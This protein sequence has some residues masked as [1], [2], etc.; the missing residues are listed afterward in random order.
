MIEYTTFNDLFRF[1]NRVL[2][3]LVADLPDTWTDMGGRPWKLETLPQ[4]SNEY[5]T[6]LKKYVNKGLKTSQGQVNT[7]AFSTVFLN[8]NLAP[9]IILN[10]NNYKLYF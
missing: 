6:V 2:L 7:K 3:F 8:I 1:L 4:Q 9:S 5:K 10:W